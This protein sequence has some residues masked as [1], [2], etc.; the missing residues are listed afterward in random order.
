MDRIGQLP[1]W[2]GSRRCS[3]PPEAWK[4]F[5]CILNVTDQEYEQ[6][7][8]PNGKFYLQLPV[9]EGKR[10]KT[11]LE[12]WIPVGWVFLWHHICKVPGDRRVLIHCNQ[13]KDRSVAMALAFIVTAGHFSIPC[14]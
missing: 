3:R 5:D 2:I 9:A 12:R 13:G 7:A 11:E 8:L 10:D 14:V 6:D 1:I 4:D